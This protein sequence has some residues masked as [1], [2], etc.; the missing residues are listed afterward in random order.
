MNDLIGLEYEWS[1]RPSDGNGKTDCFQLFCEVRKRLGLF[2]YGSSYE[3][4]Y[5][6]Y[7]E[8]S[9]TNRKLARLLL[10]NGK[11][12]NRMSTGCLALFAEI[13]TA[14]GTIVDKDIIYI[15]PGG[16]V[17]RSPLPYSTF[18]CIKPNK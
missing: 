18:Y 16:R 11:R 6:Q 12:S 17:V 13:N 9:F 4:V 1:C 5:S 2:S 3:W 8:A 7:T 10:Q 15:S 14:I